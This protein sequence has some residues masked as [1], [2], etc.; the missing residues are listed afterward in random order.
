MPPSCRRT[1]GALLLAGS[2]GVGLTAS[3]SGQARAAQEEVEGVAVQLEGAE[4]TVRLRRLAD[5][6]LRFLLERRDG[7]VEALTPEEFARRVYDEE[8]Q[9]SWWLL[10]LNISSPLGLAW[11]AVGLGG[12]L[13]FTG[14]MLLQ[15]FASEKSKRSVVPAGFWWMSLAGASMLI[16]YFV[17]RKDVVGV[18]G[19][20]TGWVIYLRN[21]WLI[22]RESRG[23]QGRSF[24]G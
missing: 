24:G 15:W 4:E 2:L 11:V 7:T 3:A 1:L 8:V 14:R 13:L 16:V 20:A 19:Q 9:R 12:Q 23:L 6:S 10:F 18:L 22:R 5:G 21:L 17:W